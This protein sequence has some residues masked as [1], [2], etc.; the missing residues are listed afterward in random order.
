MLRFPAILAAMMCIVAQSCCNV[1]D[2]EEI[3]GDATEVLRGALAEA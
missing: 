1:I 3:D 2:I